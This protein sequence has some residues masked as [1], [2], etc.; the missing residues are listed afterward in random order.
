[1]FEDTPL[2]MVEDP[3]TLRDVVDA[4]K[5]ATVIGID[6]ESDSS[7]AYQEKVCLIQVSDLTTDYIIDPLQVEDLSILGEVLADRDIVKVLHGADYDVVCLQRDY[8]FRIRGLFDTLIAAQLLGMERI[9]LADLITR[10]FGIELDKQYQR[11]NWGLRPLEIEHVEYARGD[12]HFLLALRELMLPR[13]RRLRRLRHL[14]EECRILERRRWTS[15]PFD[16]EGWMDI[17]GAHDLDE[18]GKRAL[19]ELY[20]FRD[21]MARKRNR[22]VY[23]VIPD[24]L[25]VAVAERQPEEIDDLDG[26]MRRNSALRRRHGKAIVDAVQQGLEDPR[27]LPQPRRK[28]TPRRRPQTKLRTRLRGRQAERVMAS[29]KQWRNELI[30]RDPTLT[31]F[32]VA[33]NATLKWIASMRPQ[34]LEELKQVPEVRRWQVRDFGEEILELLDRVAPE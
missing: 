9:G 2:V 33:S 28:A 8:G 26:V 4:L 13:L 21:R 32:T 6:T 31:P 12:T 18:D 30:D 25:L 27:P 24:A 10:F 17:K 19:R 20:M 14:K 11:Y 15:K 22:P 7:Y 16:P 34:N 23:K 1:M 5:S 3:S 29:L